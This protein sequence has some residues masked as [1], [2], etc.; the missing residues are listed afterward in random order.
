MGSV[1]NFKRIPVWIV[2]A[3]APP[4]KAPPPS[5]PHRLPCPLPLPELATRLGLLLRRLKVLHGDSALTEMDPQRTLDLLHRYASNEDDRQAVRAFSPLISRGFLGLLHR[6]A[7]ERK[8]LA[9][10]LAQQ[11]TIRPEALEQIATRITPLLSVTPAPA[12]E[13]LALAKAS[14]RTI[15]T[16]SIPYNLNLWLGVTVVVVAAVGMALML[17]GARRGL[18]ARSSSTAGATSQSFLRSSH[19]LVGAHAAVELLGADR[20][21]VQGGLPQAQT[22]AVGVAGDGAGPVVADRWGQGGHQHQ[23]AVH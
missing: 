14:R 17:Y 9:Q 6:S 20:P 16:P 7:P 13:A 5:T 12:I 15:A 8:V 3:A 19:H 11:V 22:L 1:L 23:A 18:G 10:A 21:E 2:M 4:P